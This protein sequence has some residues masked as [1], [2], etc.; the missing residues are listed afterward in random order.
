MI[1][2]DMTPDKADFMARCF[3][4]GSEKHAKTE[5]V[6]PIHGEW[7]VRFRNHPW[8]RDSEA[9]GWGRDLRMA[10]IGAARDRIMAGVKPIDMKPNDVMPKAE[11]IEHWRDQARKEREA[12]AWRRA[13][14]T[15]KSINGLMEID[16]E[17]L[18]RKLGITKP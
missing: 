4:N 8:V 13:N 1:P 14:P 18:L 6:E 2:S 16:G 17:A 11:Y 7:S 15:H 3:V 5:I 9:E 10:C 12:L